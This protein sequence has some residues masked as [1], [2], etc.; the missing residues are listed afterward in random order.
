MELLK[1]VTDNREGFR[2]DHC[3]TVFT[4]LCAE[5]AEPKLPMAK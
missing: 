2:I 4:G 3:K 1:T 5:C